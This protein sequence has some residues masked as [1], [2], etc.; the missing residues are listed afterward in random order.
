MSKATFKSYIKRYNRQKQAQQNNFS[1]GSAGSCV[2]LVTG[3]CVE[4]K[5]QQDWTKW[6]RSY[7]KSAH[8]LEFRGRYLAEHPN[9]CHCCKAI[10][11]LELHH[12]TYER[13]HREQ[14][15]DVVLCCDK[16]HTA[17]HKVRKVYRYM[18]LRMV[19]D[20]LRDP[21]FRKRVS[22]PNWRY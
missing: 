13:L 12:L 11:G 3:E 16:C 1:K 6:Y 17:I 9:Q 7:L 18:T 2:S 5:A 21:A 4:R 8:W 19:T 20:A 22:H 15:E 10:H 14:F